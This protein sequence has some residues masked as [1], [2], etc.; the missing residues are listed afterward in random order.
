MTT[1]AQSVSQPHMMG[2]NDC[3]V[4]MRN[5]WYIPAIQA[6]SG[7]SSEYLHLPELGW[8]EFHYN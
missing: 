5:E 7:N 2:G 3:L 4:K 6:P 1:D 8:Q